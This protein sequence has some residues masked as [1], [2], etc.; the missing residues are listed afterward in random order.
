MPITYPEFKLLG[1]EFLVERLVGR[2]QHLLAFQVCEYLGL[3]TDKVLIHWACTKVR[4]KGPSLPDDDMALRAFVATIVGKL[5]AVPGI[6][7]ADIAWSAYD[8]AQKPKLAALLLDYEPRAQ[9]QVPMLIK[10]R[11][12]ER[13]LEKAIQSGDTDLVHLVILHLRRDKSREQFFDIVSKYEVALSLYIRYCKEQDT[14]K[15]RE[16]Y[17]HQQKGDL[18]AYTYVKEAYAAGTDPNNKKEHLR[19][20]LGLYKQQ[21]GSYAAKATEEQIGLL[22]TQRDLEISLGG[23]FVGSSVSSTIYRCILMG[24][25]KRASKIAADFKVPDNRFWWLKVKALAELGDFDE[26]EK[27]SKEKKPPIGFKPFADVCIDAGNV[28]EAVKYIKKISQAETRARLFIRIKCVNIS[29]IVR[30]N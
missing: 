27:F 7:Y 10:M 9:D 1:P 5:A 16:L 25:S 3:K 20:S 18:L 24:D 22:L 29:V 28:N 30:P 23:Q 14:D 17:K 4:V 19:T 15:L 26:L 21:A 6:S 11:Q 12:P 2:H 8:V 13:A